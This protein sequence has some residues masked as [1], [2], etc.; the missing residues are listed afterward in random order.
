METMLEG[1]IQKHDVVVRNLALHSQVNRST[2]IQHRD[3]EHSI[4]PEIVEY[5]AE[6]ETDEK[7]LEG[8]LET[9]ALDL[10]KQKEQVFFQIL[11]LSAETYECYQNHDPNNCD[12]V[13]CTE[14]QELNPPNPLAWCRNSIGETNAQ[15]RLYVNAAAFA[16]LYNNDE[17][18]LAWYS[19]PESIEET[20]RGYLGTLLGTSLFTDAFRE[21]HIKATF[22]PV[23]PRRK[24]PR[25][26]GQFAFNV[27]RKSA[28]RYVATCNRVKHVLPTPSVH[29]DTKPTTGNRIKI[30]AKHYATLAAIGKST[31]IVDHQPG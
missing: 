9:L 25:H 4:Y 24:R 21:G 16:D 7:N 29:V 20:E 1:F 14:C 22:P 13:V 28:P 31:A 6:I 15:P 11:K 10:V 23:K 3:G 12:Y 18:F 19:P 2:V 26:A 17:E 8:A 30:W 27:P 5:P